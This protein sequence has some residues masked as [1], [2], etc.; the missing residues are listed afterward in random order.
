MELGGG[1]PTGPTPPPPGYGPVYSAVQSFASMAGKQSSSVGSLVL[2]RRL[3]SLVL[4]FRF[5]LANPQ[6]VGAED[7]EKP[8]VPV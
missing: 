4:C 5:S 2:S 8:E 7:S 3:T 1:R 6:K